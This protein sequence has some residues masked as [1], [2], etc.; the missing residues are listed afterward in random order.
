M[1]MPSGSSVRHPIRPAAYL[2]Q[3]LVAA[4]GRYRANGTPVNVDAFHQAFGTRPGD[5]MYK[6]EAERIRIW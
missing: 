4:Q 5:G 1:N 6:P 3:L 2:G